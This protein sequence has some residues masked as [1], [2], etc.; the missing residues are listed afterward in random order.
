VPWPIPVG[1]NSISG[2]WK[3]TV[4]AGAS[5]VCEGKPT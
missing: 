5:V 3:I 1:A 2:A 4:G